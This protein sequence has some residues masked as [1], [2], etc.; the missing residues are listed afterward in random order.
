VGPAKPTVFLNLM[1]LKFRF[2][3]SFKTKIL[4]LHNSGARIEGLLLQIFE[5]GLHT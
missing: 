3:L 5:V 2:F 4:S 1:F